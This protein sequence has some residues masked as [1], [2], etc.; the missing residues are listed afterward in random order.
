ME[1]NIRIS[2]YYDEFEEPFKL[3]LFKTHSILDTTKIAKAL[4]QYYKADYV[5]IEIIN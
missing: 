4:K 1:Y 3:Y 2:I 5:D